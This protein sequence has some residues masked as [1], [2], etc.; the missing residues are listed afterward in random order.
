MNLL[1]RGRRP[2]CSGLW[3]LQI[4]LGLMPCPPSVLDQHPPR[5]H[6]ALPPSREQSYACCQQPTSRFGPTAL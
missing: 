4:L 3:G 1:R 2:S 6:P 5:R